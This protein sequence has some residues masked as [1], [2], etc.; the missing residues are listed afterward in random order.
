MRWFRK[1]R[2]KDLWDE[3]IKWPI[4][5][6]EATNRIRN[7]CRSAADSAET[8]GG[9]AIRA[10]GRGRGSDRKSQEKSK[11]NRARDAERY[12]RAARRAMEIALKVSDDLMRDAAVSQIVDLCLKANDL[13]TA[14]ILF[15]AISSATTC[16]ASIR[17]CGNNGHPP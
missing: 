17:R 6:I 10:D 4:G 12:E 3:E 14:R 7:I 8:V 1:Q 13:K 2:P 16:L 9:R 5:D 11:E 15:R